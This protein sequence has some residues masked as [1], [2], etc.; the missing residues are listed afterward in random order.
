[1]DN[2]NKQENDEYEDG[3]SMGVLV[4]SFTCIIVIIL[5]SFVRSL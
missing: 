2:A 4:V 1:M 3:Y 5:I